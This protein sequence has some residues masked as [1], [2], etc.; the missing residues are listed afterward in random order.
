[1]LCEKSSEGFSFLTCGMGSHRAVSGAKEEVNAKS[2]RLSRSAG[3]CCFPSSGRVNAYSFILPSFPLHSS[4]RTP[5]EKMGRSDTQK[6][7][8]GCAGTR[9]V[10]FF[11]PS[12]SPS[13]PIR[14]STGQQPHSVKWPHLEP[15]TSQVCT[16]LSLSF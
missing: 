16:I 2:H 14:P 6:L 1:M 12:E 4:H 15:L 7:C 11:L 10:A 3:G 9:F 8:Q 5:A 13:L